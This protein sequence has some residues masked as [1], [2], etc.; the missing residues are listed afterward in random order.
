MQ[1]DQSEEPYRS[2]AATSDQ[3]AAWLVLDDTAS[4]AIF[5]HAGIEATEIS[6]NSF[7]TANAL[8]L[9]DS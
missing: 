6:N 1:D 7:G 5:G 3:K 9:V 2:S 4:T 8:T